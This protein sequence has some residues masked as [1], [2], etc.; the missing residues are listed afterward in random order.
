MDA[1]EIHGIV[2]GLAER[3]AERFEAELEAQADAPRWPELDEAALYGLAGEIVHAIEPST[4][5]DRVAILAQ[6]LV[7]FGNVVGRSA[8]F[9]VEA[10]RHHTN[11]YVVLVGP[12]AKGRKG[13]S[14]GWA[15]QLFVAVDPEYIGGCLQSGMSSGEGVIWAVRDPVVKT[16]AIKEKGVTKGYQEVIE[17]QGVA[18]KRSLYREPEF[19]QVLR[20]IRRE[21]STLTTTVR[22]AW[23]SGNLKVTTK[24]S[25][26]RTTGAHISIT[27]HITQEEL[28]HCLAVVEGF[29]GFANRFL[30]PCVRRSKLL[31]FGG[32]PVD[33]EPFVTRLRTAVNFAKSAGRLTRDEEADRLWAA[34]YE[35]LAASHQGLFGAV[36]S[37]AEAQVLRLSMI[38]AL[39][40]ESAIIRA[41]HL[42]AA[43]AL[44]KYCEDSAR[45]IFGDSTGDRLADKV[46]AIIRTGPVTTKEIHDGT[47]RHHS[48]KELKRV[49]DKLEAMRLIKSESVPTGGH[50]AQRVVA[51]LTSRYRALAS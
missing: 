42:R 23:D 47:N 51:G 43:R 34:V 11:L 48:A 6:V 9:V 39:L 38:Y 7:F 4:E 35:E 27:G 8:Y 2:D 24:N 36:T 29:N 49:L 15:L 5:A 18:D 45:Y 40:D 44:W 3:I 21:G 16:E 37:R 12:T 25:P 30:W 31:P 14:E 10:T 28:R 32:E 22:E 19:G 1:E 50:P 26:A 17:H 33:L 46:L 13:T 41:E 20:V